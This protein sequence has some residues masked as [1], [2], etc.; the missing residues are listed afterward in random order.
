MTANSQDVLVFQDYYPFC[1]IM[2]GR[3]YT[4]ENLNDNYKYTGHERDNEFDL[5]LDYMQ[6]RMYDPVIGRF[7]SVD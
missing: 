6:V 1:K 4:S 2:P 7:M 5:T 3:S